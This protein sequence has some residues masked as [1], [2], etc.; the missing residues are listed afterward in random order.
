[1]AG[2]LSAG[3]AAL[4]WIVNAYILVLAGLMLTCG[5]LGDR[6]GRKRMLILGLALFAAASALA[7]WTTSVEVLIA[8]RAV[9]GLGGAMILPVAF[10][11]LPALFPPAERGK[12]VALVVLGTGLGIPLGPLIGGYLL[13]NFWWGSIFLINADLPP[14]H[15]AAAGLPRHRRPAEQGRPATPERPP[16]GRHPA[17]N[18]TVEPQDHR[19]RAHQPRLPRRSSLPRGRSR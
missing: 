4:Q 10:A 1:M 19:R 17:P 15:P 5:A 9:M 13:E 11:V 6:Y 2:D 12:A 16:Q 8:A 14:V 3:T 7:T 18:A